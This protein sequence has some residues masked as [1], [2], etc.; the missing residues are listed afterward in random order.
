MSSIAESA[1]LSDMIRD[2]LLAMTS[3]QN[4]ANNNL[5]ASIQELATTDVTI[6][7]TKNTEGKNEHKEIKG[8]ALAFGV[9]PTLMSIQSSTI[10]I[11]T[12]L[13]ATKNP[14]VNRTAKTLSDRASYRFKTNTV[15]AKY[16]NTY[17]YKAESSS[18]IK[19]TIVPTP[20]S[21]ELIEAV[22]ALTKQLI[23]EDKK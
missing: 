20:P 6:S 9:I 8:N 17:D 14:S 3:S 16:Q 23:I 7:Y 5:I 19:I 2:L 22:K 11:R 1:S 21:Q 10:E 18:I 4:E 13:S 12:T 15:D